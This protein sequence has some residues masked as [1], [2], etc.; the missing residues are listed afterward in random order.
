[1]SETAANQQAIRPLLDAAT[2]ACERGDWR[3]ATAIAE[4]AA[5]IDPD[6]PDVIALLDRASGSTAPGTRRRLTVMFCDLAGSTEIASVLDPEDTRELLSAYYETCSGIVRRHG[7]HVAHLAGDGMLIYFGYPAAHEDDV[8]RAVLTGLAITEAVKELRSPAR[9]NSWNLQVR[10]GIHTGLAVVSELG[11]GSWARHDEIVGE[12][13]NLAARV[14]TAAP[15]GSVAITSDTLALVRDQVDVE[16]LGAHSLKGINR[17][18]DLYRV[19]AVR[20]H[21][22]DGPAKVV[23]NVTVGRERELATLERAWSEV[24]ERASYLVI[25]GEPGMGKSHLVRHA[26]SLVGD[27][28]RFLVLRCSALHSNTPLQPVSQLLLREL[29][30]TAGAGDALERVHRLAELLNI[31]GE[32]NLYLLAVLSWTPWPTDR[33]VP[34]LQPEQIRERTLALLCHWF[35]TLAAAGPLLLAVEDLHWADPSTLDLLGRCVSDHR[36]HPMEVLVT[37]RHAPDSVPGEPTDPIS[38]RALDEA[39]SDELIATLTGGRLDEE[40]RSAVTERGDGVPLYLRELATM[41]DRTNG[42]GATPSVPPT[43]NDLLVAR[44]DS[45]PRQREMVEALAVLGRPSSPRLIAALLE[46]P[47]AEV[48]DE[49][50]LLEDAGILRSSAKLGLYEFHHMLLRDT[51]YD[52]QLLTSRRALHHRAAEALQRSSAASLADY[53]EELAHHYQLAGE[54]KPAVNLLIGAALQHASFAAH[55]EAIQSFES[56]LGQLPEIDGDTAD[57]ELRARSGLAASLLAAR[58]YTAPE[59]EAAY[60]KVREIA[61]A[62]DAKLEVSSLYGLWAYYHVT[63]DAQASLETAEMLVERAVGSGDAP[64]AA[65]ARAVLG[66]QLQRVGRPSEAVALLEQGREWDAPEPLF[67]HHPGIGAGANLA[68]TRWLIGDFAGARTSIADAV[69]AAEAMEGPTAHFTRAYTHAFAAELFHVAGEHAIAAAHAGRAVEIS[70]EFGFTSWLGAGLTNL[71]IAEA[72]AGN[73]D[74][75]P[76][77]EYCLNAWRGSGAASNLTQFG[78][79]LATVYRAADRPQDALATIEQALKDALASQELYLE[80]ELLRVKGELLDELHHDDEFGLATLEYA[81]ATAAI[82]GSRALEL[83]TLLAIERRHRDREDERTVSSDIK[84]LATRLDPSGEDPEAILEE[85]RAAVGS[86]LAQ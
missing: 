48:I 63:G 40:I 25:S 66:Y 82:R 70:N 57:L 4:A 56:V 58:G 81:L 14:Q 6:H 7:G 24:T 9:W 39:Q 22:D 49:L 19:V 73:L 67:P 51:A 27:D 75:I 50:E 1:V 11:S 53:P 64:A 43:L 10:V 42:S 74:A 54:L 46:R 85:A 38:L 5:A 28:G 68:L 76:T 8:L 77:I 35:D 59:V 29:N 2:A 15:T 47:T 86:R 32:E 31:S 41:L 84:R 60:G 34:D 52:L 18:V 83:R 45:F 44:L 26:R 12:A 23:Q 78:L 3:A 17:P 30:G 21:E 36:R 79:G 65:A 33:D 13:P 37:T 55:A 62:R 71:K 61:V 16:P 80:P 20:S 69:A 72:L